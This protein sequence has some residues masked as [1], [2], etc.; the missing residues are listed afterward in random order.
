MSVEVQWT[1]TDPE[2]GERR[3]VS[4]EKFARKWS[5]KVRFKRRENWSRHVRET[6]E[7][8]QTLLDA[9]ERRYQRREGVK[10]EDLVEVRNVLASIPP[11]ETPPEGV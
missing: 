2:T 4:A 7:M 8:W 5:F 9:L 1:D 6:R 3:F 11:E 10:E